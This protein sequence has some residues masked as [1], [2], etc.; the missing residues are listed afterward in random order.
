MG[1]KI[2]EGIKVQYKVWAISV[3]TEEEAQA[4][5]DNINGKNTPI[6]V[7]KTPLRGLGKDKAPR[8]IDMIISR[9]EV[10]SGRTVT[11]PVFVEVKTSQR[12]RNQRNRASDQ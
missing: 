12:A 9:Q 4:L 5:V 7:G 6:P 10:F 3:T 8:E 2:E 1:T 11:R